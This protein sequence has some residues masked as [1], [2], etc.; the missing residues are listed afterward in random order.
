L[1]C[2]ESSAAIEVPSSRRIVL[3]NR[4]ALNRLNS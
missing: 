2:L 4:P 3:C 1:R